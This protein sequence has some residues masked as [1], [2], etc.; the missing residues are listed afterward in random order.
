MAAGWRQNLAGRGHT[1]CGCIRVHQA[2]AHQ[3]KTTAGTPGSSS[4]EGLLYSPASSSGLRVLLCCVHLHLSCLY[5][6]CRMKFKRYG[7][8]E[9]LV[10]SSLEMVSA[11]PSASTHMLVM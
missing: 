1:S 5:L 7:R 8:P 11:C 9:W 4:S 10:D 2:R 3:R 6:S